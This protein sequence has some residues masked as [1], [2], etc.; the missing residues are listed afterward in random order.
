M[1]THRVKS[2]SHFFDAIQNGSKKHDL[3]EDDRNFKVGDIVVLE[4]YDN[5]KGE[6]TGETLNT[7]ITYITSR[8]T[9]CAFSSVVLDRNF[10]ILSLEIL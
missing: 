7:K 10:V 6:Y 9:P 3:R 1:A 2:W 4:R 8:A 5:I